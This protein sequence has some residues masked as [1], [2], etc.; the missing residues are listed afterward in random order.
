[1]PF[2]YFEDLEDFYLPEIDATNPKK[3]REKLIKTLAEFDLDVPAAKMDDKHLRAIPGHVLFAWQY[4]HDLSLSLY[5]IPEAKLSKAL[6]GALKN[7]SNKC[8][9]YHEM[10]LGDERAQAF[11]RIDAA[12]GIKGF[13]VPIKGFAGSIAKSDRDCLAAYRIAYFESDKKP[14][15][16]KGALDK[17]FVASYAVHRAE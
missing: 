2:D 4:D 11:V 15:I 7:A 9:A 12:M 8:Y 17:R 14:K 13:D 3:A 1:M 10:S 6:A 16:K 5:A